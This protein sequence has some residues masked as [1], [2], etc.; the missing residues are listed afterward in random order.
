MPQNPEQCYWYMDLWEI[1]GHIYIY[2]MH[3]TLHMPSQSQA[4]FWGLWRAAVADGGRDGEKV[5]TF[6]SKDGLWAEGR[7]GKEG[8]GEEARTKSE[9]L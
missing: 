2:I 4:T 8:E 5:L 9:S 6:L 3:R 7:R 1:H